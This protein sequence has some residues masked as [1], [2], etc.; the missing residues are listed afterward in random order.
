MP[1]G[2][3][4]DGVNAGTSDVI[5]VY[6]SVVASRCS[7]VSGSCDTER[8]PGVPATPAAITTWIRRQSSLNASAPQRVSVGG[9]SGLVT[10]VRVEK[11]AKLPSC[12]DG[13]NT[14]SVFVL[15][16]GRT[17]SALDHGVIDGMTMRLYLLAYN[18]GTLC[19]ELDDIDA[20]PT[21]MEAMAGVAE[22]LR[23]DI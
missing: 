12:S 6:T 20:A 5:G 8:V 21:T 14:V 13:G 18:S 16:S 10:D 1:P 4:L 2:N 15:I 11:G 23:F 9:L 7:G 19:I 3:T 22:K 17:P